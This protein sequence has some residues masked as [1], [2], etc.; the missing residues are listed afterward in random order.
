[1]VHL[2]VIPPPLRQRFLFGTPVH[3]QLVHLGSDA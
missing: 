1:L 3:F 2:K